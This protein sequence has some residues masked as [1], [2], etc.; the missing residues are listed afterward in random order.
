M[1]GREEDARERAPT[2]ARY[3]C[4]DD[5]LVRIP[6]KSE[7]SGIEYG[8]SEGARLR[9]PSGR[10]SRDLKVVLDAGGAKTLSIPSTVRTTRRNALASLGLVSVAA[11]LWASEERSERGPKLEQKSGEELNSAAGSRKNSALGPL[12]E[13]GVRSVFLGALR[14]C[15]ALR[16]ILL[17]E[18]LNSVGA[19][20]FAESGLGEVVLPASVRFIKEFAFW[21]CRS[22]KRVVF[23]KD[24]KLERIERGAFSCSGL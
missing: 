11:G 1:E 22:L 2:R 17:P 23:Q 10:F 5:V 18:G 19:F 4:A 8:P 16:R 12:A 13:S 20:C 21:C 24:S 14:G 15:S 6:R 7:F 3:R 9:C